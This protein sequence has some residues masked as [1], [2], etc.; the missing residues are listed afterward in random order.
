[1]CSVF[2]FDIRLFVHFLSLVSVGFGPAVQDLRSV[3]VS[4]PLSF[5]TIDDRSNFLDAQPLTFIGSV[6]V[7]WNGKGGLQD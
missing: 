5:E 3:E 1:M 7:R 2:T 4:W 6:L